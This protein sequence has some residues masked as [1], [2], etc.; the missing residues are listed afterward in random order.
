MTDAKQGMSIMTAGQKGRKKLSGLFGAA[1]IVALVAGIFAIQGLTGVSCSS[2]SEPCTVAAAGTFTVTYVNGSTSYTKTYDAGSVVTLDALPSGAI[3]WTNDAD[4]TAPNG[5]MAYVNYSHTETVNGVQTQI[6]IPMTLT[7]NNNITL[8]ANY[9]SYANG[10]Q[11]PRLIQYHLELK[12][13]DMT[14]NVMMQYEQHYASVNAPSGYYVN[15][16]PANYFGN[17]L[18]AEIGTTPGLSNTGQAVASWVSDGAY[19][20]TT[21]EPESKIFTTDQAIYV[22]PN[23]YNQVYDAMVSPSTPP[24]P[25]SPTVGTDTITFRISQANIPPASIT[26]NIL[27]DASYPVQGGTFITLWDT[28]HAPN[29]HLQTTPTNVY[30]NWFSGSAQLTLSGLQPTQTWAQVLPNVSFSGTSSAVLPVAITVSGYTFY[31][32]MDGTE[33]PCDATCQAGDNSLVGYMNGTGIDAADPIGGSHVFTLHYVPI[34]ATIQLYIDG[35]TDS[36]VYDGSA[37]SVSGYDVY[38]CSAATNINQDDLPGS[39]CT[40]VGDSTNGSPA[41]LA[42]GDTLNFA[43]TSGNSNITATGTDVGTYPIV[44]SASDFSVN[45]SVTGDLYNLTMSNGGLTITKRP[46]IIVVDPPIDPNTPGTGNTSNVT[47]GDPN[48][49]APGQTIDTPNGDGTITSNT[50]DGDVTYIDPNTGAEIPCDTTKSNCGIIVIVDPGRPDPGGNPTNVTNNYDPNMVLPT[51]NHKTPPAPPAPIPLVP[52]T[53]DEWSRMGNIG[54]GILAGV[55][56]VLSICIV[57]RLTMR[58]SR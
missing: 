26:T 55:L 10:Q 5:K 31:W 20:G 34:P 56:A 39:G 21:A 4:A 11:G 57:T 37:H 2:E 43:N 15:L 27:G 38:D 29:W 25:P 42:N 33:I 9:G 19:T 22:D 48:D 28:D 17:T 49:L 44:L 18:Y 14:N 47:P 41:L 1:A 24:T 13:F 52:N 23:N 30:L 40:K 50:G 3:A 32:D 36:V 12:F 54:A 51:P 45:N 7:L 46:I 8:N 6:N 16:P 35:H 53:G 58:K